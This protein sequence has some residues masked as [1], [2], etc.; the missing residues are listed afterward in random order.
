MH[1]C[2]LWKGSDPMK[3][4]PHQKLTAKDLNDAFDETFEKA[5]I[6][7]YLGRGP[8][9]LR[10]PLP[11]VPFN[12]LALYLSTDDG[13]LSAHDGAQWVDITGTSATYL[14]LMNGPEASIGVSERYAR[15][16]HI[17]PTDTTVK[18]YVDDKFT[19]YLP[20]AGGI[21]T[22]T[23]T[24]QGTATF[25]GTNNYVTGALSVGDT[26]SY[27]KIAAAASS[28][29]WPG[30]LVNRKRGEY[31][32]YAAFSVDNV[33]RWSVEVGTN[34]IDDE[35]GL[36][37]GSDMWFRR[38][39]DIGNPLGAP[40]LQMVRRTG[41]V[42]LAVDPSAAL[43]AATKGYVDTKAGNYLPLA[44]GT[45]TGAL[46]GTTAVMSG[47]ITASNAQTV[48]M[49]MIGGA[50]GF[51]QSLGGRLVVQSPSTFSTT[52]TPQGFAGANDMVVIQQRLDINPFILGTPAMSAGHHQGVRINVPSDNIVSTDGVWWLNVSGNAGAIPWAAGENL[53]TT[54]NRRNSGGN[55]YTNDNTGICGVIP[56]AGTGS[57]SDGTVSWTYVASDFVCNR[58]GI[59]A[60]MGVRSMTGPNTPIS[61][62]QWIAMSGTF[63]GSANQGGTDASNASLTR[64]TGYG[65]GSQT[66]LYAGATNWTALMG[67]EIDTGIF[68]GG[69]RLVASAKSRWGINVAS[70]GDD[71]GVIDDAALLFPAR[72]TPWGNIFQI[73]EEALQ[74]NGGIN[75][76]LTT[77]S[78]L[79][80]QPRPPGSILSTLTYFNPR[81]LYGI[82]LHNIRFEVAA[83]RGPSNSGID[84]LGGLFSGALTVKTTQTAVEIDAP[85]YVS[86]GVTW[87]T[88]TGFKVNDEI[89]DPAGTGL[90]ARVQTVDGTGKPLTLTDDPANG[91][92]RGGTLVA[93]PANPIVMWGG[94][95]ASIGV[96]GKMNVTWKRIDVINIGAA[97][98]IVVNL[99]R[100]GGTVNLLGTVNAPFLPLSGGIVTGNTTIQG[101][102]TLGAG[103]AGGQQ[104]TASGTGNFLFTLGGA[105]SI[106]N[107]RGSD[108]TSILQMNNAGSYISA[109]KPIVLSGPYTV[110]GSPAND[111]A[112]FMNQTWTG[113]SS[114]G[115]INYQFLLQSVENINV[116]GAGGGFIPFAVKSTGS[117]ANISGNR[118]AGLFWYVLSSQPTDAAPGCAYNALNLKVDIMVPSGGTD[119][120]AVGAR[121]ATWG[122]NPVAHLG[123]L[124]VNWR[125]IVGDELNV[126]NEAGS[127]VM[128][129]IGMQIVLIDG[130]SG[131]VTRDNVALSLNNQTG[132]PIS[133][134]EVGFGIGRVGGECPISPTGYI[135]RAV[136]RTGDATGP[137]ITGGVD[138]TQYN[139]TGNT[140][141]SPGFS[142]SGLGDV[143]GR[144]IKA[145]TGIGVFNTTPPATKPTISGS[146]GAALATIVND[147]LNALASFGYL[148][149]AT[150]A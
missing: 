73:G 95:G 34:G 110:T 98:A 33:R 149:N 74:V 141:A 59:A 116:Q 9:A 63:V 87:S 70:Y 14:P 37:Y 17:H 102:L 107:F 12:A 67:A 45:L 26:L 86:N 115:V 60:N 122:I 124:A 39:D 79:R 148:T 46:N 129:R 94:S 29:N 113:T 31:G 28:L 119:A 130:S 131:I 3:F 72:T 23:L 76:Q 82:D 139:F 135:M 13:M 27:V 53:A 25:S 54:G 109:R 127:S 21:V 32:T 105:S 128:D 75:G 15:E 40:A 144:A 30:I 47:Q 123:P 147:L 83:Y 6:P 16:D 85:G 48:K 77:T 81:A 136:R 108:G 49:Q 4:Q 106:Y 132:L 58:V 143:V 65:V 43:G 100:V 97:G 41:E 114:G 69:D 1:V 38:L 8:D 42:L 22:G 89:Y 93:P 84:N 125:S 35:T 138:F 104:I 146:R 56:P 64:G 126:W 11:D 80:Y 111:A 96:P 117:G 88:G 51:L 18:G 90:I 133:A 7:A 150:T 101:N 50:T 61:Q 44:G 140:F 142:V 103:G 99:G 71:Q 137:T 20:L 121:G 68:N 10:P 55:I 52:I 2:V 112:I 92:R 78:I 19:H 62:Y 5:D 57:S 145:V 36:N 24:V 134:W 120:T 118:Q 66:W 91:G